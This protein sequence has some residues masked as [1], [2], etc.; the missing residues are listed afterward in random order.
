VLEEMALAAGLTP[1]SAF[2]HA[3][4][5]VYPD[6]E[7]LGR[8][9]LAPAGLAALVGPQREDAVRAQIVDAMQP[10]R[11]TGGAYRIQNELHYLVASA[12]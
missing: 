5:Y 11:T 7:S 2:D 6:D 3:F 1:E 4:A 10:F 8:L 9:L 12:V